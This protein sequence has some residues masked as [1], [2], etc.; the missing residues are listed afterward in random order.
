MSWL[1]WTTVI[2]EVL[3]KSQVEDDIIRIRQFAKVAETIL[4]AAAEV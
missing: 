2:C 4:L 3:C 1:V